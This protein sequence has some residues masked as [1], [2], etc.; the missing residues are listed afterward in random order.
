MLV[1]GNSLTH[2][3]RGDGH[4]RPPAP[5][6]RRLD[7][8]HQPAGAA[9]QRR[10]QPARRPDPRV[11]QP[12]RHDRLR[13]PRHRRADLP[14]DLRRDHLS[15]TGVATTTGQDNTD[16]NAF[17]DAGTSLSAAEVT[18]AF[19][20]VS[21]ALGYWSN[22]AKTG[23]TADAYLTQPVGVRTLNFGQ[24]R[25]IDLTA[26]N[27]PDGINSILQWTS[28][29]ATISNDATTA[30]TPKMLFGHSGQYPSYSRISVS[31][32]IAAI[33]GYEA[34]NYL[35]N[36]GAL[37]R[38]D[39]NGNGIISSTELQNFEDTAAAK[40]MPTAGAMARLLGGTAR[41][42]P[43]F[44]Q[45]TLFGENPD[46]PDVL[47]RR[48]NFFDYSADGALN[49]SVTIAALK[50]LSHTVM[51]KPDSFVVIDRQKSS[52]NGF[53]VAPA[54]LR[55]YNALQHISPTFQ[56]MPPSKLLT[57]FRGVSPNQFGV[58]KGLTPSSSLFPVF[59]L[60]DPVNR[61]GSV[62]TATTA[63]TST[64]T[65]AGTSTGST[66]T[67][68]TT[69]GTTTTTSQAPAPTQATATSQATSSASETT[70]PQPR[71]RPRRRP[72]PP[73][74]RPLPASTAA[75]T[76]VN[77]TSSGFVP[78][79]SSANSTYLATLRSTLGTPAPVGTVTKLAA[80]TPV[81]V[82]VPTT[83][84]TTT[85]AATTAKP[86]TKLQSFL[87]TYLGIKV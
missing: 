36:V 55:N 76:T 74:L 63:G 21:S 84:A 14:P 50:M 19:A 48:F 87:K 61:S 47:Q 79:S 85:T 57:K 29:P 75:V 71:P 78:Y 59:T 33:E 7:G 83:T 28:V 69:A 52:A 41:I 73:R 46:Q 72:W 60:F 82:P 24:H 6:R 45:P 10:L 64:V 39:A 58:N 34:L 9:V 11:G 5:A 86:K 37:S 38:I 20:L 68:S 2:R 81:A 65:N 32:A 35:I 8:R 17:N 22:L 3:R 23:Y 25:L 53:L 42:S 70:R 1:F 30:S 26:W 4:R 56:F 15:A 51:P 13:G 31:N 18:G 27:N 16:H 40:G 54:T 67:S 44:V 80:T 66:G 77:S 12:E 49:G 62:S 43:D